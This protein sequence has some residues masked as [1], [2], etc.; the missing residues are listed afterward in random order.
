MLSIFI[1][2][3][4][5]ASCSNNKRPINSIKNTGK[6]Q[7][8]RDLY[9]IYMGDIKHEGLSLLTSCES[10]SEKDMSVYIY[11][12]AWEGEYIPI[13]AVESKEQLL[14][15]ELERC[16]LY[17][18]KI[19]LGDIDGDGQDEIVFHSTIFYRQ[20]PIHVLKIEGNELV[21]LYRFPQYID[22]LNVPITEIKDSISDDLINFGFMGCL[23]DGY[24]IRIDFLALQFSKII[25]LSNTEY[26]HIQ[27]DLYFDKNGKVLK[28]LSELYFDYFYDIELKDVNEDGICDIIGRQNVG[29]QY[30]QSLGNV[31]IVLKY[32]SEDKQ[33]K[34][35]SV[36][37][38]GL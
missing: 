5:V 27:L 21:E 8:G 37:F 36:D 33:M 4:I 11:G 20:N 16:D 1:I 23:L 30:K 10:S 26:D 38:E 24:K 34:V 3:C 15:F 32:N 25:D 29:F 22:D 12:K 17:P 18:P 13:L 28:P 19:Y 35:M 9:D 31:I 2:I 6:D 14:L 7:N